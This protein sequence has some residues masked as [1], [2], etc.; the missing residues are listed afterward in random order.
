MKFL[1]Y[2]RTLTIASVLL[3]LPALYAA[4]NPNKE[5][6]E[7]AEYFEAL[8]AVDNAISN[9]IARLLALKQATQSKNDINSIMTKIAVFG[10]EHTRLPNAL[11]KATELL[12]QAQRDTQYLSQQ[13]ILSII[14]AG[15]ENRKD[16]K[17]ILASIREEETAA[18]TFV[19]L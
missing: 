11:F 10:S 8:R 18:A 3:L 4:D 19:G 2:I 12:R 7:Y 5:D 16:D 6:L 15:L 9:E 14:I 13:E 1:L 17:E